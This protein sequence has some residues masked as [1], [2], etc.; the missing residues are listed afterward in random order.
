MTNWR[1]GDGQMQGTCDNEE[2]DENTSH[3]NGGQGGETS[4]RECIDGVDD[5]KSQVNREGA[6]TPAAEP[7]AA[8]RRRSKRGASISGTGRVSN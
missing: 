4:V 2:M 7:P 8:S 3:G 6:A 5:D 1:S